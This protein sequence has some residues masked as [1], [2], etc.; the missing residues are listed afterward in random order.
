[1]NIAEAEKA[2][3][4]KETNY[5]VFE[6][7]YSLKIVLPYQDGVNL[8]SALSK[9]ETLITPYGDQHRI[10][11]LDMDTIVFYP[12]SPENYLRH[13]MAPLLGISP[14]ELKTAAEAAMKEAA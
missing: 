7:S 5:L 8:L 12:M 10:G 1:M 11:E 9:A 14:D 6:L 13:K 2:V 4:A 3:K